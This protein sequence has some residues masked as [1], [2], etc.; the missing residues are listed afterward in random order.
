MAVEGVW[1]AAE[2]HVDRLRYDCDQLRVGVDLVD[3]AHGLRA[4]AE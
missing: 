2:A 3:Y 4:L 1:D